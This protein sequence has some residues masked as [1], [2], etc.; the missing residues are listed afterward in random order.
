MIVA[1][2]T[3]GGIG[4]FGESKG[5]QSRVS[6]RRENGTEH[7]TKNTVNVREFVNAWQL[8]RV[9]TEKTPGYR[10]DMRP[11]GFSVMPSRLAA[12]RNNRAKCAGSRRRKA[13]MTTI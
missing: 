5:D 7:T 8:V 12:S 1:T 11:G 9:V 3:S 10:T 6:R 13:I 4:N 2:P